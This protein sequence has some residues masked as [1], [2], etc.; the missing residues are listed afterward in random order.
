M[1]GRK[2]LIHAFVAAAL[3]MAAAAQTATT[4]PALS[5]EE[6][7][8]KNIA[9]RG[10]LQAWHAI[11]TL[12]MTGKMQAGGNN[13]PVLP[14][15]GT[16]AS[17]HVAPPRATEQA[18]LPFTLELKRPMKM[19][20]EIQFAGKT[21]LQVYDGTNGWKLRPYLNRL[22]VEPYTQEEAKVALSQSELDGPLVDYQAKGTKIEYA[23]IEKVEGRDTYKLKMTLKNGEQKSIWIDADTFLDARIEGAPRRLDGVYHPVYIYY[24]DFRDV[25]G[26]KVPYVLETR[27]E[28][29]HPKGA[30]TEISEQ[31]TLSD[32]KVNPKLEDALFTK[33]DVKSG[34]VAQAHAAPA[35]GKPASAVPTTQ[36][37][38]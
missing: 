30:P 11:Q 10:G 24:R 21:A 23:G 35:A 2:T 19:R 36:A 17:K 38:P 31:I 28:M 5:A 16:E 32:V 12:E 25:S 33:P 34:D 20:L 8:R 22:E 14:I 27:V 3:T 29:A 18:Q 9:A 13:R 6:V 7:V 4:H 37:H 15:P 1:K 26:V